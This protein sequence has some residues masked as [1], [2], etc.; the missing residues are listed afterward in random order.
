MGAWR[1]SYVHGNSK[2]LDHPEKQYVAEGFGVGTQS[3]GSM[4]F[5]TALISIC[6]GVLLWVNPLVLAGVTGFLGIMFLSVRYPLG[7]FILILVIFERCFQTIDLGLQPWMYKDIALALLVPALLLQWAI[8][9]K[10]GRSFAPRDRYAVF[11][12]LIWAVVFGTMIIGS[13]LLLEQPLNTL[14]FRTRAAFLLLI[15]FYLYLVNFSVIQIKKFFDFLFWSALIVSILV[16]LDA[17]LLGGG[18]IF[19]LAM[20]NG[21]SGVRGGAVRIFTYVTASVMVFYYIMAVLRV[22]KFVTGRQWLILA[23]FVMIFQ[24]FFCNMTRQ[25]MLQFAAVILLYIITMSAHIR[26]WLLPIMAVV[27]LLGALVFVW[28]EGRVGSKQL[29]AIVEKTQTELDS[30]RDG[31]VAVR[32]NGFAFYYPYLQKT[33]FIG[34]GITSTTYPGSPEMKGDAKGY[35]MADLGFVATFLKFGIPGILAT[36]VFFSFIFID[37]KYIYQKGS[38]EVRVLALAIFYFMLGQVATLPTSTMFFSQWDVFYSGIFFYFI[39]R[40]KKEVANA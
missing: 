36:L 38:E 30:P 8:A 28:S 16:I 13:F 4:I 14:L 22:K 27:V 12:F 5:G 34:M 23:W 25:L 29:A 21:V 19:K 40:L 32:K 31:N 15:F 18:K 17:K 35:L 39:Y 37:L 11:I 24:F 9:I 7:F 3:R 20:H 26:K 2:P 33:W 6:V 10:E 1:C